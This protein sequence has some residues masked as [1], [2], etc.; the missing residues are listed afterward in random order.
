M[1]KGLQLLGGGAS[2]FQLLL[3]PKHRRCY[4]LLRREPVDEDPGSRRAQLVVTPTPLSCHHRAQDLDTLA[5]PARVLLALLPKKTL[6]HQ[7]KAPIGINRKSFR[8]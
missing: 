4:L 3:L 5:R 8:E 7:P 6:A 1:R 2:F